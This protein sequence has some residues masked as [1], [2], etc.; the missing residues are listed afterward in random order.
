MSEIFSVTLRT[1]SC[2]VEAAVIASIYVIFN[3]QSFN[4]HR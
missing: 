1:S 4:E 3:E 2:S